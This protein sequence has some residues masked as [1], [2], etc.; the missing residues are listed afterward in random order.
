MRLLESS[1]KTISSRQRCTTSK[2][3][4]LNI[5]VTSNIDNYQ[6]CKMGSVSPNTEFM[7]MLSYE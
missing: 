4:T 3:G 1:T 5:L 2:E 7:C 6:H